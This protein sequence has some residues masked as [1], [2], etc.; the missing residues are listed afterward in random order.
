MFCTG[1][2]TLRYA[3]AANRV[4]VAL[5]RR[6]AKTLK[7]LWRISG[8]Q[9]HSYYGN[10]ETIY[11]VFN[12]GGCDAVGSFRDSSPLMEATVDVGVVVNALGDP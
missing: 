3:F 9:N 6:H 2:D 4:L 1:S 8:C 11:G 7:Q 10:I 5:P 12:D